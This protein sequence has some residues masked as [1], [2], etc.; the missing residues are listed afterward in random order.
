MDKVDRMQQQAGYVRRE[1]KILRKKQNEMLE[2]KNTV[3]NVKNAFDGLIRRL[4]TTE[5][6]ISALENI[7]IEISETEKQREP[8]LKIYE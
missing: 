4:D 3:T 6:V 7:S 5:E 1:M 2:I 8:R